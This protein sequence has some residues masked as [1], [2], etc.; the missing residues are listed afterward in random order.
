MYHL[1][2][3]GA[4]AM[5]EKVAQEPD[6]ATGGEPEPERDPTTRFMAM[7]WLQHADARRTWAVSLLV[8]EGSQP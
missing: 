5:R 6:P 1:L 8:R 2:D 3:G 7:P 4:H